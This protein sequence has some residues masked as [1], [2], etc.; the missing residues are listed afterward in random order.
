M[1]PCVTVVLPVYNVAL[2]IE[3][4][5]ASIL[6]QTF[7]DFELLVL[8][9]CST[10]DTAARVQSI[11]DPRLRFI[12]NPRNL[13]RAGT[14]NAALPHV[15]GQFIAKMDG[16]DLCHPERL[17][18]QVAFLESNPDVN[19]VGAWIQNFGASTYLNRYPVSPAAAQVLTLFTLATGNPAVMLRTSLFWDQGLAYDNALRQ[20]EDYDFFARYVRELRVVSLPKALIQYRVL[21]Y[22]NAAKT[23]ILAERATV[24]DEVRARLLTDWGLIYSARELQVYNTIATLE[25]P[26]GDVSLAEVEAW[27]QRLIQFND[28]QPLFEPT[29]LR[30]GL[31]ERWFE[32]CYTHSQPRLGSILKFKRSPLARYFSPSGRQWLKFLAKAMTRF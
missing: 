20:T 18:R 5:I 8:D 10:D 30:Q 19:V 12:Q 21:P 13:G 1:P 25:R 31:G 26:L 22:N 32:V 9:D 15:R 28:E 7:T 16:D 2:Y 17:A 24:S 6:E 11:R 29:A 14:D 4:T 27:L 3:A 23:N